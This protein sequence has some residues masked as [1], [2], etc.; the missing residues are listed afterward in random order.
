M[1]Q[2]VNVTHFCAGRADTRE[3]GGGEAPGRCVNGN[4]SDDT[5]QHLLHLME[6]TVCISSQ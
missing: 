6:V 1:L 3:A 2:C 4:H 5:A